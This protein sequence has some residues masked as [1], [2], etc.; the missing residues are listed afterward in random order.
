[1]KSKN[2][3]LPIVLVVLIALAVGVYTQQTLQAPADS[4]NQAKL[5][6]LQKAIILPNSKAISYIDFTDHLGQPFSRAQLLGKWSILF[7]GFTNCP[8]ICPTTLHTLAQ[9][10]QQL[11]AT[12]NWGNYQVVM[13]SV[14]PARDTPQQL[15]KYVPFFDP[16]FIGISGDLDTT[17][18]FAKQ[19]G[20]LFVAREA[21]AG[22]PATPARYDVDHSTAIVLLNPRAEMAGIISSPHKVGEISADL[23]ALQQHFSADHLK[24]ALD[25]PVL[26]AD[27]S[28][29]TEATEVD[30]A[31][32]YAVLQMQQAW[33]RPAPPNSAAMAAYFQ[34]TNSSKQDIV[35]E[36]VSSAAF[37]ETMIHSSVIEQNVTRMQHL[38][39]LTIK[40]NSS[41]TF[42]PMG[43]HLMLIEPL[44]PLPV[45]S[46]VEVTFTT[47][48][49]QNFTFSIAV[50]AQP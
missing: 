34:L 35:I 28:A 25:S 26:K 13:V 7:F 23:Q 11:T 38:E 5:P 39:N 40:A 48:D 46:N 36:Q 43:M 49:K 45:G 4:A 32:A 19:L 42:A 2:S 15:S 27:Y 20:I 21:D 9:V 14:D 12:N 30:S 17:T 44:Q 3:I 16:E 50:Q 37:D 47:G 33:I 29:T 6:A 41:V 1:M 24:P 8:D 31:P 18:E 22:D 10:K